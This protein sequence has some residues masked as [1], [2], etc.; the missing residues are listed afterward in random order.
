M[1]PK[2]E[3]LINFLNLKISFTLNTIIK[4]TT[5]YE[6][7]NAFNHYSKI[8]STNM[9]LYLLRFRDQLL[10][11]IDLSFIDGE[12]YITNFAKWQ[13]VSLI[14]RVKLMMPSTNNSLVSCHGQLNHKAKC[15]K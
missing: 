11:K 8:I 2:W 3:K 13:K 14:E 15:R 9:D 4:C 10:K 6:I 5:N 1:P 7:S 12:I